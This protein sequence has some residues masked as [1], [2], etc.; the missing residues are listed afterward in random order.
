M[1][2]FISIFLLDLDFYLDKILFTLFAHH[3][4]QTLDT[5]LDNI[6]LIFLYIFIIKL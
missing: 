3:R 5:H 2:K 4:H 6:I 1:L